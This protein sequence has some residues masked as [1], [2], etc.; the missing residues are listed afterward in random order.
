MT[1]I[2]CK[3]IGYDCRI[4]AFS[5]MGDAISIVDTA[6]QRREP[7]HGSAG[8]AGGRIRHAVR[9]GSSA[10]PC[11]LPSI[12]GANADDPARHAALV[13]EARAERGVA[14]DETL[15]MSLIT[16]FSIQAPYQSVRFESQT[17]LKAYLM[18][19]YDVK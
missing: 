18:A 2:F 12:E 13:R 5:H 11:A 9:R 7:I 19:V 3:I 15:S 8:A 6:P 14:F 1:H 10:H 4:T 17:E 16:M